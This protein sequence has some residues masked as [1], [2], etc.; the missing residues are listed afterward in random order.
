MYCRT[1]DYALQGLPAAALQQPGLCPEC[2]ARFDPAD[3]ATYDNTPQGTR[4]PL[5]LRVLRWVAAATPASGAAWCLLT[6]AVA[7]IQ[8]G[9]WPH[10]YGADDPK[11]IPLVSDMMVVGCTWFLWVPLSGVLVVTLA[12]TDLG[13]RRAGD[14]RPLRRSAAIIAL[15]C[16]GF[17]L[18]V[19]DPG[20]TLVWFAD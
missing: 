6:L 9:R 8:L 4:F 15:W 10:R 19:A 17:L 2:G 12:L 11:Y 7:R 1:C 18:L 20:T 13:S 5:S 3:P 14:P 16:A